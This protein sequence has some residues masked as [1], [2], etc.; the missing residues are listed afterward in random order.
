MS[1]SVVHTRFEKIRINEWTMYVR[2]DFRKGSLHSVC[3]PAEQVDGVRGPFDKVD[4]SDY[5]RVSRCYVGF[6]GRCRNLYIKQFL[7]R[8]VWDFVKHIF[9][10]SRAGRAFAGSTTLAEQGFFVPETVAFVERRFGPLCTSNFLITRELAGAVDLYWCFDSKNRLLSL[11][12]GGAKRRFIRA[13]G[14]TIGRMHSSG[15][16]HGDLR[17]GNIFA[18]RADSEWQFFFLDNERTRKLGLLP[19]RLRLKNLVQVNMLQSKNITVTDRM[20]FFE[21]YLEQNGHLRGK[22]KDIARQ[23]IVKTR[24]RLGLSPPAG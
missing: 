15:I 19:N 20:R 17:V 11:E 8:S 22:W 1:V 16:F 3:H 10:P 7:Y 13:L 2:S 21:A 14:E 24:H 18:K 12:S 23:I 6:F 9:R 5:A 4:S